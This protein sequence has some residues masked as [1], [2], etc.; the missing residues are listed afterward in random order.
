MNAN[1]LVVS[2]ALIV[3]QLFVPIRYGFIPLVATGLL[4]SSIEILP[5]LSPAR[6]IIIVGLARA[7]KADLKPFSNLKNFDYFALAFGAYV[8]FSSVGH[9]PSNWI[10]N[11]GLFRIGLFLNWIGT[12]FYGRAYLRST[13]DLVRLAA[14]STFAFS[15]LA[16][17][18]K[19]QASTGM[20]PFSIIGAS[21]QYTLSRDGEMRAAGPFG[22]AILAGCMG[23]SAI[24]LA[25]LLWQ[26]TKR[27][28]AI[29]LGASGI[30][31]ALSSN[32]SGPIAIVF[33]ALALVVFWNFR[34]LI[35]LA[36]AF[37]IFI[38]LVY[39]VAK[40]RPPWFIM[41]GMDFT[42]GSTGWHRAE[43]ISQCIF[44]WY[45]WWLWGSDYT[46]HW[47]SSG[48]RSTPDHS[49]LTNF[50]VYIAVFSGLPAVVF[51]NLTLF[52]SINKLY[53]ATMQPNLSIDIHKGA[54][55]LLSSLLLHSLA[56]VSIAYFD[57]SYIMF[58]LLLGGA[59]SIIASI[60]KTSDSQQA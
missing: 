14:S 2:S 53:R 30:L 55:A 18:M 41:A 46:R 24:P 47:M 39:A 13:D 6:I 22:H 4:L 43:L 33:A 34:R 52:G 60:N 59:Q 44:H 32:S 50:Y 28:L 42:G 49:D 31:I 54:W 51:F 27:V 48:M 35:P 40:G 58:F 29:I 5:E 1:F 10:P 25:L 38:S 20:N 17:A 12:Y 56:F 23:A 8:I 3:L 57:Q 37:L 21:G 11:P 26:H 7:L 45:E 9:T 19:H 36:L 15:V 16:L